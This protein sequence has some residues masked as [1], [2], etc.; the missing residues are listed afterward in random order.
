MN[1]EEAYRNRAADLR[2]QARTE[3]N[4]SARVDLELLALGYDRL[5]DQAQRNAQNNMVYEYDPQALER[6]RQQ[7]KHRLAQVQQQQPQ[8]PKRDQ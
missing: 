7:R 5:A 8:A 4:V 1:R 2:R 3:L 6:R